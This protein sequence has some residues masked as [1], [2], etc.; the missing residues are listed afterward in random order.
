MHGPFRFGKTYTCREV[1]K[2]IPELVTEDVDK[3]TSELRRDYMNIDRANIA[4][5]QRGIV[6]YIH[7]QKN[8]VL[9]CGA[10]I[11]YKYNGRRDV[12]PIELLNKADVEH[13]GKTVLHKLYLDVSL[14]QLFENMVHSRVSAYGTIEAATQ[15]MITTLGI[16]GAMTEQ[17]KLETLQVWYDDMMANIPL[18]TDIESNR[19]TAES[20]GYIRMRN[21]DDVYNYVRE[22]M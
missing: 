3:F 18:A 11:I 4:Q 10:A 14:R 12:T 19:A 16:T 6:Q 2:R 8:P 13:D 1:K 7:Q 9:M 22:R 17:Q 21:V 5:A 20:L 15:S